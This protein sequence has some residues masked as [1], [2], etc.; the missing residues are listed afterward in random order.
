MIEG[1]I[2]QKG[3][4]QNFEHEWRKPSVVPPDP[5]LIAPTLRN[6]LGLITVIILKR[7]RERVFFSKQKIYSMKG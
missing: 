5:L 3:G 4:V 1:E 2:Q 6:V 7:V